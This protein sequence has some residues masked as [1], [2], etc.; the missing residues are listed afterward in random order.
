MIGL[1]LVWR[2]EGYRMKLSLRLTR[3]RWPPIPTPSV[4][5]QKGLMGNP[6]ENFV[7]C[8][9]TLPAP[10]MAGQYTHHD[11]VCDVSDEMTLR[12]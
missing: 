10:G 5:T 3:R 6:L 2:A 7:R 12:D 9:A 1:V 11:D 4:L 8:R